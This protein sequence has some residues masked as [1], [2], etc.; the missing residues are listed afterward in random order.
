MELE[1]RFVGLLALDHRADFFYF[2]QTALQLGCSFNFQIG[3]SIDVGGLDVAIELG[4][5]AIVETLQ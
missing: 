3:L 5:K 4:G 1:N 2:T